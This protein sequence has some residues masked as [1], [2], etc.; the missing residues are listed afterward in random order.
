MDCPV[1][2]MGFMASGKSSLGARLAR[3]LAIDFIDL[4]TFIE[5]KEGKSISAIFEENGEEY[6]R[7]LEQNALQI[8]STKIAVISLGGGTPCQKENLDTIK[9][10]GQSFYLKVRTEVLIGRLKNQKHKRPLVAN[11]ERIELNQYVEQKLAE[12]EPFYLQANFTI[13]KEKAVPND[14]LKCLA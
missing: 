11:M 1:Y 9:K 14:I 2:L 4:D 3:R 10:T 5:E 13:E 12:R 7:K 6:F 8:V